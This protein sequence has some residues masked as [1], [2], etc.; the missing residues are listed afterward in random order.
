MSLA[1]HGAAAPV[2]DY[3]TGEVGS[4]DAVLERMDGLRAAGQVVV[5]DTVLSRSTFRVLSDL[6]PLLRS[7][8]VAAWRI[9]V[10]HADDG[11]SFERLVPRLAL[12]LPFALHALSRAERMALSGWIHGAPLCLLGP[13]AKRALSSAPRAYGAACQRC[14]VRDRCPGLDPAYLERF[15]DAELRALDGAPPADSP[16]DEIAAPLAEEPSLGLAG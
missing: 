6:P 8:G 14:A 5:V 9:V 2:H 1:L 16:P 11:L 4:F 3:H 15:G 10:P 12:A 13:F 7:R